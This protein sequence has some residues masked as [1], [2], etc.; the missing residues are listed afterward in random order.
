MD[1]GGVDGGV[2]ME[3]LTLDWENDFLGSWKKL[4]KLPCSNQ[5]PC[6]DRF[7]HGGPQASKP[8][9][10]PWITAEELALPSRWSCTGIGKQLNFFWIGLKNN[11]RWKEEYIG[12][13]RELATQ[14]FFSQRREATC[15]SA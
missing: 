5:C 12:L 3:E 8:V 15:M 6:W 13:R 7:D 10:N 11:G 4:Q 9:I 14:R 1:A 2:R